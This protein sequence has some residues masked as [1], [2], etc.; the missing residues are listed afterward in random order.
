MNKW[1][2]NTVFSSYENVFITHIIPFN[3]KIKETQLFAYVQN[4]SMV[5]KAFDIELD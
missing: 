1:S 4:H 5:S 3:D 2:Q